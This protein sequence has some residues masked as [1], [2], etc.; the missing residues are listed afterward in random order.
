MG[1]FSFNSKPS[2]FMSAGTEVPAQHFGYHCVSWSLDTANVLLDAILRMPTLPIAAPEVS[3]VERIKSNPGP[4]RL[5]LLA[6]TV[7]TYH[8]FCQCFLN[9]NKATSEAMSVGTLDRLKELS[10]G[11]GKPISAQQVTAINAAMHN[12]AS[13]ITRQLAGDTDNDPNVILPYGDS[14][15]ELTILNIF[16]AYQPP[17]ENLEFSATEAMMALT[18][19]LTQHLMSQMTMIREQLR[20]TVKSSG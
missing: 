10:D 14:V 16:K 11:A 17:A 1:F 18:P 19:F 3:V 2:V 6:L 12:Y 9:V 15:C 5:H 8:A 7:A 13:A 20:L 4:G